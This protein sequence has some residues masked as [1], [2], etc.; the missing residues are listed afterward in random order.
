[1]RPRLRCS[2][3]DEDLWKGGRDPPIR[4]IRA[5][6]GSGHAG[7]HTG[8][9]F[10]LLGRA[11]AIRE[12][13]AP[14]AAASTSSVQVKSVAIAPEHG[15][16]EVARRRPSAPR[17]SP[18]PTRPSGHWRSEA[19]SVRS[20]LIVRPERN[21]AAPRSARDGDALRNLHSLGARAG[22]PDDASQ[23]GPQRLPSICR[24]C[25]RHHNMKQLLEAVSKQ[26]IGAQ[27]QPDGG[28]ASP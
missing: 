22:L 13:R 28:Q 12:H 23:D 24:C 5:A 15:V 3:R 16:A 19:A 9:I 27:S 1:V 6:Q 25:A 8:R 10:S 14:P 2:I 18:S 17:S 26:T 11:I 7:H 21:P 4:S 20:E